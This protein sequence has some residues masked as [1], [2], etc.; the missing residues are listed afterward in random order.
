MELSSWD[1]C[2]FKCY[3]AWKAGTVTGK[4][5][6]SVNAQ[7]STATELL[8]PPRRLFQD[9]SA[10]APRDSVP[11]GP[12]E[13]RPDPHRTTQI[14][15]RATFISQALPRV[16]CQCKALMKETQRGE[17][18]FVPLRGG[19]GGES[20]HSTW[21]KINRLSLV[22]TRP[23]KQKTNRE[24]LEPAVQASVSQAGT[25]DARD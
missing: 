24:V 20:N 13:R 16:L 5:G 7:P 12:R 8:Q 23:N 10:P 18:R 11:L 15:V 4:V 25:Q 3:S 19:G 21:T 6:A 22:L 1:Y 2:Q 14:T 9:T 17:K